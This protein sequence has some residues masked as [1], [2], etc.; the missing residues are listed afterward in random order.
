MAQYE[1]YEVAFA[2]IEDT[3]EARIQFLISKIKEYDFGTLCFTQKMRAE[4]ELNTLLRKKLAVK[5]LSELTAEFDFDK[6]KKDLLNNI[7]NI[8]I[9]NTSTCVFEK[10]AE[11]NKLNAWR[12]L[13]CEIEKIRI[14]A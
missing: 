10:M 4:V 11:E 3:T 13:F 1:S 14:K 9:K 2:T 8:N 5:N 6:A 7:L 12:E